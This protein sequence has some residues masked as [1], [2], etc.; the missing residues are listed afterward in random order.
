VSSIPSA[1]SPLAQETDERQD[2]HLDL[3]WKHADC[4]LVSQV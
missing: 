2:N 1:K 4:P 3:T